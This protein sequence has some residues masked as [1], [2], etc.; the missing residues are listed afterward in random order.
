MKKLKIRFHL[1]QGKN[2]L[3]WQ[4][5][6]PSGA[7]RYYNPD[8]V[9]LIMKNG[10]LRN[11]IGTA[12]KIHG[13]MHKAVCGWIEADSVQV[14]KRPSKP[15]HKCVKVGY[16]PRVTPTWIMKDKNADGITLPYIYSCGRTLFT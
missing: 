1:A 14:L 13:G 10:Y 9:T 2:H 8:E 5:K 11:Q 4:V 3:N 6:Y 15:S 12:R 16:N 7:V